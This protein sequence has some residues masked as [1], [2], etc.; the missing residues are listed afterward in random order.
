MSKEINGVVTTLSDEKY[1]EVKPLHTGAL[2]GSS[3]EETAR[4]WRSFEES[5][6]QTT[7]LQIKTTNAVKYCEALKKAASQSQLSYASIAAQLAT[8]RA[9]IYTIEESMYGIPAKNQMGEK[10]NPTIGSRIFDVYRGVGQATYGPTQTN[11]QSLKLVDKE[12]NKCSKDLAVI[13][14]NLKKLAQLLYEA[15]GPFVEG[16]F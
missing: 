12:V 6:R 5:I 1:F 2:P 10:N 15:G 16:G 13:I 3:K 14:E 8:A 9:A 4:F 7:A 11:K